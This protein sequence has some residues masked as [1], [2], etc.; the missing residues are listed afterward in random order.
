[1]EQE[2]KWIR[3]IV[4]RG[5][6]AAAD[7]L[8]RTYYDELYGFIYRQ[9]SHREDAL[10][11][12][13]DSLIAALRSLP[14]YDPRKASFRTWLYRIA[15]HK[16]I[17]A[18]R[19]VHTVQVPLSDDKL[20]AEDDFAANIADKALLQQIEAYICTLDPSLQEIYRLRLYGGY[21]FPEI[22]AAIGQPEVKL[23]AQYYRLMQRL[24]KEFAYDE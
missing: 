23:K 19:R 17:D 15:T 2:Q 9:V 18:R 24:R 3:A 8:I 13:Q 10:D 16:V 14:S 22:A 20:P 5:S 12:T 21:S 6:E 4:R 7:S 1:M 11:L